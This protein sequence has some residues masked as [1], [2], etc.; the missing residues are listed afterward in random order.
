[1]S[2][3]SSFYIYLNSISNKLEHPSNKNYAFTNIIKPSIQLDGEYSVALKNIFFKKEFFN[4]T[5]Y[6]KR[7]SIRLNVQYRKN[8]VITGGESVTYILTRSIA[9]PDARSMIGEIHRDFISFLLKSN[10]ISPSQGMCFYYDGNNRYVGFKPLKILNK[11]NFPNDKITVKWIFSPLMARVFGVEPDAA[12]DDIPRPSMPAE[13]PAEVT[14]ILVYTDIVKTSR[15]SD[16]EVNIL[17]ILPLANTYSKQSSEL[18]YKKLR[19]NSFDE[20]SIV[21]K[22]EFGKYIKFTD[23]V[24]VSLILHFKKDY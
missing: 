4:V 7:Y 18:I 11:S 17:D 21:L 3:E 8:G 2:S 20:I 13:L 5:Q 6:D 22:D 19:F 16:V 14:K 23:D 15:H 9:A 12:Y 10:F 24:N 1:M